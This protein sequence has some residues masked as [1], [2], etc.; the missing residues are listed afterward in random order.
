MVGVVTRNQLDRL[1]RQRQEKAETVQLL[2]I[3]TQNPQVAFSDEPLRTVVNRMAE[4]GYTR[5]PVL[6]PADNGG[7][8]GMVALRD[9]LRARSKNLDEER[10]RERVLR[11]RMPFGQ[12]ASERRIP[13]TQDASFS[14]RTDPTLGVGNYLDPKG[15]REQPPGDNNIC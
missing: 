8:V 15:R 3:A 2:E 14:S 9:L 6:D 11:I 13:L 1:Y 7:I 12:Q 5:L 4:S 10:A